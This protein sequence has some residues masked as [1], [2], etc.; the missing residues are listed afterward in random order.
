MTAC[1]TKPL[2]RQQGDAATLGAQESRE[3]ALSGKDHW[4]V[5][6]KL[7][8]SNGQ[9]GGSGTLT[10]RQS[11]DDYDFTVRGPVT[12]KSFRLSGGP[13]GATLE[14]LDGGPQRGADAE[15]LMERALGWKLPMRDLQAWVRGL[16]ADSGP[17]DIAFGADGLPSRIEQDGWQVE[18]RAW[19]A[20]LEPALPTKVFAEHPPYK[21]RLSI[22]N[23]T[24]D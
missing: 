6:G 12:G 2:I 7:S 21:V 1:T 4:T 15:S 8:V 9:D 5:Q 22:D 14:G 11:G 19:N 24:S 17:A 3:R 13:A 16:R 10:W 23:W 18:Y 20:T